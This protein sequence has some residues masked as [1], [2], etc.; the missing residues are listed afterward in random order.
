MAQYTV[1]KFI[2]HKAK[3]VGPFTFQQ[4]IFIGMAGGIAFVFYYTL[5]FFLFFVGSVLVFA[6]GAAL[7]FGKI[8]GRPIPTMLKS[9][10]YFTLGPK[11]YLWKRKATVPTRPARKEPEVKR[12]EASQTTTVRMKEKSRLKNL[13]MQIETGRNK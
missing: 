1:P 2:D 3:I 6:A 4:F 9:F 7:A 13:S 11:L 10:V 8:N 5:P 12:F